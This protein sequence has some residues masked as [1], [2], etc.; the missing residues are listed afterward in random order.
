MKSLLIQK[1]GFVFG[2]FVKANSFLINKHYQALKDST[3]KLNY[4]NLLW[5]KEFN[6]NFK[7]DKNLINFKDNKSKMIFK[8]K[9]DH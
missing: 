4:L 6:A 3:E 1:N 9:F 7:L 8:I 5:Q 2:Y